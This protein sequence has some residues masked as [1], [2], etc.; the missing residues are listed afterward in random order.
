MQAEHRCQ[1]FEKIYEAGI[2]DILR[3]MLLAFQGIPMAPAGLIMSCAW[4]TEGEVFTDPLVVKDSHG[5]N[6]LQR[7]HIQFYRPVWL[8]GC[9]RSL[10]R[11]VVL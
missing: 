8:V 6:S 5:R 9:S 7:N 10:G 1:R 2:V 11:L 3:Q 4:W